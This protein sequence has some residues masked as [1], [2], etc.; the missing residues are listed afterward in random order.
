MRAKIYD[1][2]IMMFAEREFFTYCYASNVMNVTFFHQN[3][4]CL[5]EFAR[6]SQLRGQRSQH[7]LVRNP[8]NT[9]N[10][11]SNYIV[12]FGELFYDGLERGITEQ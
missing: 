5:F 7:I 3:I 12:L 10:N 2:F 9:A 6:C 4:H 8:I 11:H 1:I